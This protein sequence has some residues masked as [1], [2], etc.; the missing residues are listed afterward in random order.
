MSKLNHYFI[1]I[2]KYVFMPK[3]VKITCYYHVLFT[4]PRLK[5]YRDKSPTGKV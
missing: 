2:W 3:Y 4:V 5:G 1:P